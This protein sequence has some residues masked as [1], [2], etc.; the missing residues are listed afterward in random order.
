MESTLFNRERLNGAG[1]REA[2]RR[3]MEIC[4]AFDGVFVGLWHN[5]LWD[6]SDA[7][8][9]GAHFTATLDEAAEQGARIDTLRGTL[10]AWR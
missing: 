7:P 1:A 9:W 4:R 6:E 10:Q 3:I 5:I 8:G 2:T